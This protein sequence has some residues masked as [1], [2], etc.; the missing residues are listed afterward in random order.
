M[1]NVKKR[2]HAE[3]DRQNERKSDTRADGQQEAEGKAKGAKG[4]KEKQGTLQKE[5]ST[6]V[7]K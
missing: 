4:V 6:R 2:R 5:K 3:M 7:K 1:G